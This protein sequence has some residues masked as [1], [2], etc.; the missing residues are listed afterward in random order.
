MKKLSSV[1]YMYFGAVT[2]LIAVLLMNAPFLTADGTTKR[3]TNLFWNSGA[4]SIHGF[5]PAFMG[6]MFILVAAIALIVLGLPVIQPSAK[7]EKIVLISIIGAL[8]VGTIL[9][10]IAPGV[11]ASLNPIEIS[12]TTLQPGYF[13]FLVF[14][15]LTI[16]A[17]V[18]ALVKDW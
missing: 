10:A 1:F 3:A 5:W 12:S 8:V 2:G 6:F 17:S 9:I 18:V 4:N 16:A 13:I 14:A 15:L 7:I 11:Y